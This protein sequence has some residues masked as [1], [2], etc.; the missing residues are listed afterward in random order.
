MLG[1][2][3]LAMF[4]MVGNNLIINESLVDAVKALHKRKSGISESKVPK[5]PTRNLRQTLSFITGQ[6]NPSYTMLLPIDVKPTLNKSLV[7]RSHKLMYMINE[8]NS[9]RNI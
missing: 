1:V 4:Y 8:S 3:A 9:I 7:Q 2:F 5:R 6:S